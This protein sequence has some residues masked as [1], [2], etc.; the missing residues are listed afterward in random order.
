MDED[1]YDFRRGAVKPMVCLREAWQ[2]IKDD[3]WLF[4]GISF[5][6]TLLGSVGPLGILLGPAMCGI[7]LCLL[8]RMHDK[9]VSFDMLFR[10]FDYFGQ[11]FIAAL[12]IMVPMMLFLV[13]WYVAFF[14]LMIS[15]G[16]PLDQQK[17]GAPPNDASIGML[18]G[19][20]GIMYVALI[21]VLMAIH[22]L[23]LFAF[24]LIVDRGLSGVEAAKLSMKAVF[25]NLGGVIGLML[26]TLLLGIAGEMACCVGLILVLPLTH[27]MVTIAYGQV[28]HEPGDFEAIAALESEPRLPG[29][30][31]ITASDPNG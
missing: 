24:P 25:G 9:R 5:V 28:F 20:M 7:H 31:S 1:R 3:Y 17:R 12:I 8:R 18:F 11:S 16:V 27:A 4:L 6:G 22:A 13:L 30:T 15:V 2:L 10:G 21:V 23:F 26:L 29:D 19:V 14:A